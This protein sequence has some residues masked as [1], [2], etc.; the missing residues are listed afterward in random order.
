M[1]GQS[2]APSFMSTKSWEQSIVLRTRVQVLILGEIQL[3]PACKPRPSTEMYNISIPT[4]P[5]HDK[6][7]VSNYK[8]TVSLQP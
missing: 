1:W 4:F 7:I 8:Y 6:Q 3:Q 5:T 2:K